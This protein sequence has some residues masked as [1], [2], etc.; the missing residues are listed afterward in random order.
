MDVGFS[1]YSCVW[2][3]FSWGYN[4][5][6]HLPLPCPSGSLFLMIEWLDVIVCWYGVHSFSLLF[7]DGKAWD[8]LILLFFS[9]WNCSRNLFYIVGSMPSFPQRWRDPFK[10]CGVKVCTWWCHQHLINKIV[11]FYILFCASASPNP[12]SPSISHCFW[13]KAS[14]NVGE[15]QL[16]SGN[17]ELS[18]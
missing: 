3:S 14:L 7:G 9:R 2:D 13:K 11:I 12:C 17:S 16:R 18:V 5:G 1:F 15:H 4:L 6:D 8:I 10:Q